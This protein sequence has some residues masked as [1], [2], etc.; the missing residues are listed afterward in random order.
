MGLAPDLGF[1]IFVHPVGPTWM[2]GS[3]VG[4]VSKS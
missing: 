2:W 4:I 3:S 1:N